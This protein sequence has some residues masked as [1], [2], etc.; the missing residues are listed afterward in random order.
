MIPNKIVI[1]NKIPPIKSALVILG[2]SAKYPTRLINA[3]QQPW[4]KKILIVAKN[5][6]LEK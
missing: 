2:E 5:N 3:S 4:I 6:S 1:I